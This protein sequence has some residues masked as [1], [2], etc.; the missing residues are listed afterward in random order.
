MTDTTDSKSYGPRT[1]PLRR[2]AYAAVETAAWI[3]L[4]S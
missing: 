1:A 4:S 2:F 3:N